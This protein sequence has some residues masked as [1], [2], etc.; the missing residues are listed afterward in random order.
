MHHVER[1]WTARAIEIEEA[2]NSVATLEAILA[3]Q[4]SARVEMSANHKTLCLEWI[5]GKGLCM[6]L[7]GQ[8][9]AY[10][11]GPDVGLAVGQKMSYPLS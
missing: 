1:C 6:W 5:A 10:S 4:C 2:V 8:N 7:H 9:F 11:V 3:A